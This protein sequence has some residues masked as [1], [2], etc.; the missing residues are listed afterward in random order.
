VVPPGYQLSYVSFAR[1]L[2][3]AG[4]RPHCDN[5]ALSGPAANRII[6]QAGPGRQPISSG[7]LF[8]PLS[9]FPVL[10][11]SGDRC[12]DRSNL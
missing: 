6:R 8:W 9:Y 1:Q 3:L 4:L 10:R 5:P 12:D 11:S 7:A 2:R